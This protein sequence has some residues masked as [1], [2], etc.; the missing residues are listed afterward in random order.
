MQR[1]PR[2][3]AGS[4]ADSRLG[5][6]GGPGWGRLLECCV[7]GVLRR[8]SDGRAHPIPAQ[9]LVGRSAA[10]GLRL[11]SA[12]ASSEHA[13]LTWSGALWEL[14]DLGSKNGT[15]LARERLEPGR[16]VRLAEG[17]LL[18][19]G[20]RAEEWLLE[21]ASGPEALALDLASGEVQAATG[22]LLSLPSSEAPELS[23]YRD[24][25]GDWVEERDDG[26][27]RT[28]AH[29]GVVQT[30]GRAWRV[31][32]PV[33][34]EGTPMIEAGPSLAS[35]VMRFA[36]SRDEERVEI[37]LLHQQ[38]ELRLEPRD[39]AYVLLTLARARAA[40]AEL[41]PS[42]RGWVDREVLTRMLGMDAN[43]LNVAIHRA[44][45]QLLG[46]GVEDGQGI[47]ETRKNARRFGLDRF[48]VVPL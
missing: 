9:L 43:A 37:T 15:Y 36:V 22:G 4:T 44:R 10:C 42:E 48:E 6:A 24:R 21:D 33:D 7:V 17:D 47:V 34:G 23:I 27:V 13:R 11:S 16:S 38:R 45:H 31:L 41:P 8:R 28:L 1:S 18:T 19:F 40:E 35:I 25:T 3:E 46:A 14:R 32:L 5:A 26:E 20:D 2:A 29:E 30:A 12:L 39:H